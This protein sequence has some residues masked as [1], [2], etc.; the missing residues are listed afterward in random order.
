[1]AGT[2]ASMRAASKAAGSPL[3]T[4]RAGHHG[5]SRA[6]TRS[7]PANPGHATGSGDRPATA[8][9]SR[10]GADHRSRARGPT[11]ASRLSP[12][13]AADHK[14][15]TVPSSSSAFTRR[16]KRRKPLGEGLAVTGLGVEEHD[17]VGEDRGPAVD[18]T[19]PCGES[20][21]VS[22]EPADLER[23]KV[24]AD[25]TLEPAAGVLDPGRQRRRATVSSAHA[26]SG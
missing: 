14:Q 23:R 20:R 25:L 16:R 7:K 9:G 17:V 10:S 26:S 22:A 12:G 1:M 19:L 4:S 11:P 13:R 18:V 2:P 8:Q 6:A 15:R 21:R 5:P 24:L 3:G